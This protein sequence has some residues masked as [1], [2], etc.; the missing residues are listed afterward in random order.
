MGRVFD[1]GYAE[2]VVVPASQ[3]QIIP[4]TRLDWAQLGALPEMVQ[5]AWGSLHRALRIKRGDRLLIRGCTTSVGLA[6]MAIA[7][8]EGCWVAATTRKEG[9]AGWLKEMG[10]DEVF[11]DQ[12]GISEEVGSKVEGRFDKAGLAGVDCLVSWLMV[13]G[14]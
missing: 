1:G 14:A 4:E 3:V 11:V 8:R 2:Y 9:R 12:G 7:K 5:T 13:A 6:A 10:A